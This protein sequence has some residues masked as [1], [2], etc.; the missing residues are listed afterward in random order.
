V[1]NELVERV[2]DIEELTRDER[3]AMSWF[4]RSANQLGLKCLRIIDAQKA[5]IK[6][7]ER[8]AFDAACERERHG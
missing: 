5:E 3:A 2:M 6:R 8:E 4:G 7:L 1:Y